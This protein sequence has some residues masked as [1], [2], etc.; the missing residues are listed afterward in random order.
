[1][2]EWSSPFLY[3]TDPIFRAPTIG[4]MLMCL[5]A[6]LVGTLVF[7]RRQSL[8]GEALSHASYPG[9]ILGILFAGMLQVQESDGFL[10]SVCILMGAASTAL[11]G[12]YVIHKMEKNMRV[13]SDVALCFVLSSFFGIGIALASQVQFSFTSLYK[14]V[15]VYLYG[16]AA[17]MTDRHI[18][19]YSLL[20][21]VVLIAIIFFYKE[22]QVMAFDRAFAKSLGIPT[23][24]IDT[25]LFVLIVLAVVIGIR[26]VG[27]VLMSA[28]LIAPPIAARQFT[29]RLWMLLIL[30]AFFGVVSGFLGNYL[31]VELTQ[32]LSEYGRLVLPTGPMIVLVAS[33]ICISALLLAPQ[34]GLLVRLVRATFFRYQCLCENLLKA[35]WRL[36]PGKSVDYPTIVQYQGESAWY[37]KFVL[38]RM[39]ANGWLEKVPKGLYRLTKEGQYRAAN[40]VRLHR[41]WEVYLVDYIGVGAERV[42]KNAEEMEHILTPELERELTR[43]LKDPKMD[44]HQQ[45]I[46][47]KGDIHVG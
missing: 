11:L 18:G 6:G 22:I 4:S 38:W 23:R 29:H 10:L 19:I 14:Q 42:H 27:V 44:P 7:L 35:I 37:L 30:S 34:R 9:V 13:Q 12:I 17:T 39:A 36:G 40:I 31:S 33:T 3:F 1:M 26:S 8:L 47:S 46:P 43:L 28:M 15:Q 2:L 45:P 5:T 24:S 20:A 25:F 32:Q 41:L 21:L 16:Q